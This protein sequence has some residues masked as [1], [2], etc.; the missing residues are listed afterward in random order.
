MKCFFID[1]D[2]RPASSLRYK[3][4]K[5]FVFEI[6]D[7]QNYVKPVYRAFKLGLPGAVLLFIARR[8][9]R[10]IFKNEWSTRVNDI[11]SS[12]KGRRKEFIFEINTEM[13]RKLDINSK[14]STILKQPRANESFDRPGPLSYR[15]RLVKSPRPAPV[16]TFAY[17]A[18]STSR[19]RARD[20]VPNKHGAALVPGKNKY[21][22]DEVRGRVTYSRDS[23]FLQRNLLS[24][25]F[26]KRRIPKEKPPSNL[27]PKTLHCNTGRCTLGTATY[28]KHAR[29]GRRAT[30]NWAGGERAGERRA[31][32][33]PTP[34]PPAFFRSILFIMCNFFTRILFIARGWLWK[35]CLPLQSGRR[36]S[37]LF[38]KS[39]WYFLNQR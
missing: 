11:W 28:R 31:R 13:S 1:H 22:D 27:P 16:V 33:T 4:L 35:S 25:F 36:H 34:P 38:E 23:A 30:R 19:E 14:M 20:C 18:R 15:M 7:F 37:F 32:T 29:S 8:K 10:I 6:S 21:R 3:G 24:P 12:H 26:S 9:R 2:W 39:N 5:P 17:K